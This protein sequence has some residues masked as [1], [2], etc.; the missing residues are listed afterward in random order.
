M[1][2]I[3]E[4]V[5]KFKSG[6][7]LKTD[8][9]KYMFD[10]HHCHLFDYSSFLSK[11]N[12]KKI[13]ILDGAVIMTT[14]NKGLKFQCI[15]GDHRIAP[16][17]TL[18][19]C[20]YEKN[21]SFITENLI[22]ECSTFF[23]IGANIGY[24][25]INLALTQRS[26]MVYSFEPIP[27][28]FINLNKNIELN[29]LT[30]VKSHNFGF[31]DKS[32]SFDFYTYPEG[33]GNASSANLTAREDVTVVKCKL[34]TLDKYVLETNLRVD[35]IKCDVEG[36]ELL[37]FKGGLKTIRRDLPIIFCELLRKWSAKFSYSPN[38]VLT[39]LNEFGYQAYTLSGSS[40][41]PIE[42]INDSTTA[43]NFFFLHSKKH[44]TLINRFTLSK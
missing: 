34:T 6:Q 4:T 36:S 33:S 5:S 14:R 23:D 44:K 30:N 32:G 16:I 42:E 1:P 28:T 13:E 3:L 39:L 8:F 27:S 7:M 2:K 31:S 9:I 22:G 24:Y 26:L 17:E 10:L 43:T 38:E 12:I 25:S 29:R 11:T 19:F 21:E 37:V 20:D 15:P 41:L 35:F 40:I 18:N